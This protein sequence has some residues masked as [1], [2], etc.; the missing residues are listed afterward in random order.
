LPPVLISTIAPN[1]CVVCDASAVPRPQPRRGGDVPYHHRSTLPLGNPL[2]LRDVFFPSVAI[3]PRFFAAIT[4][5]FL[6]T[7]ILLPTEPSPRFRR[8]IHDRR[9]VRLFPPL[10]ESLFSPLVERSSFCSTRM[11][12]FE[13]LFF[14]ADAPLPSRGTICLN[15]ALVPSAHHSRVQSP[16]SS[17]LF[18]LRR[19]LLP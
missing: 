6:G 7:A 16:V 8:T 2:F 17:P 12:H 14:F 19:F 11:L 10:Y 5:S 1:D 15:E 4:G 13:A 18:F 3:S 9:V